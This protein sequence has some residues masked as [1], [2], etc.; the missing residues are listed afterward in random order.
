MAIGEDHDVFLVPSEFRTITE[1]IEAAVRPATIMISPGVYVE[2]LRVAG[3]PYLVLQSARFLRRGVT[4][5]GV[6]AP[7][8]LAIDGSQVHLS[9][10]DIRSNARARGMSIVESHVSLQDC[11]VSGNHVG[12]SFDQPFGAGIM[13]RSST[14]RI[15]RSTV[16]GNTVQ[17]NGPAGGGG[18]HFVDCNVGV[19]GS[20][21]QTN[22]VYAAG[23]APAGGIWCE[24][25]KIRMWRSRV[26]DN[27]MYAE[28]CEGAGIYFRDSGG[29]VIAGS[30]ITG[31]GSP[32]GRGGGR[33][34]RGNQRGVGIHTNSFGGRN[35]ATELALAER[36]PVATPVRGS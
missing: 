11:V 12:E 15:Q 18:L 4:V 28:D 30:V 7:S 16:A 10:I 9:G 2:D 22:A 26:T 33:F 24:R 23:M 36:A 3:K 31:N 14:V 13:G 25:S 1:A 21:V 17:R 32:E 29:A 6:A 34:V 5:V 8:V 19:M 35:H 20:S 27:V